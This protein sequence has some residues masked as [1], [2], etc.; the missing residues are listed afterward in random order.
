MICTCSKEEPTAPDDHDFEVVLKEIDDVLSNPFKG[1]APWIG[2]N[3]PIYETKLQ[4]ATYTWK[5]L[6]LHKGQYDWGRLEQNWG[7]V[8]LTGRRVGFRI[9][10]ALPGD[11]GHVDIPQW[12]V[13][14]GIRMRAY[15][16]D[17]AEG[18]APD[19]D[20]PRFLEAHHDF[21][22]AL[23]ARYDN[24]PRVAWIDIGSYGFWGEWHV[25]L[26]DSLAATQRTKQSILEDYFTAFPTKKK[27]I[28][29]DDDFATKYV[30]DRG[31]GIRNDC[32]GTE[33]SN[34]WYLESLNRIDPT[35]NDRVW[36]NAIITG[37]FCG[38]SYGAQ[39]GTTVRFDLNYQFI[40]QTHWSFIGSAGGAINP[41]DEEHRENLDNLHKKLGY[42]FVLKRVT[43]PASASRGANIEMKITVENKGVAP[44]YYSWPLVGYLIAADGSVI[45]QQELAVDIRQWLP[46]EITSDVN[47]SVPV[48][49]SS[50]TCDIKLAIHDPNT[51]KPG[52]M[53][54]NTNRDEE[55]RYLVSRLKIN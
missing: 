12:L 7:N 13:D 51:N 24:D 52:V 48:N 28:A 23:G 1:F 33:D 32:L 6:E 8:A 29:F 17:G 42:R 40:Q 30:T 37:E 53:F 41:V 54:A 43:R 4:Q 22:L 45:H 21:I 49:I 10:A 31:G 26:N 36:K 25:W 39:Q 16:I 35:L 50:G 47:I 34:N 44:F 46:G 3:N 9:T 20:D 15:E 38:S 27:V 14:Q 11:P 19:W 2:V 55:G 18:L 5:D